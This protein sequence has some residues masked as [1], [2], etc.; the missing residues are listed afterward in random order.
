MLSNIFSEFLDILLKILINFTWNHQKIYL[1]WL[2]VKIVEKFRTPRGHHPAVVR[3]PSFRAT[4]NTHL[5]GPC[6]QLFSNL[7]RIFQ[8][9]QKKIRQSWNIPHKISTD[10]F[11]KISRK[12][13]KFLFQKLANHTLWKGELKKDFTE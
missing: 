7:V 8:D 10:D 2:M 13:S 1:I 12:F 4:K 5:R 6:L 9:I 3:G 11:Y